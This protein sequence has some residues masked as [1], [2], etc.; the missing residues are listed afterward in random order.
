MLR[1]FAYVTWS[2]V[3][4]FVALHRPF[5]IPP[6]EI[7]VY[8]AHYKPLESR[9][10]FLSKQLKDFHSV[11]W[12]EDIDKNNITATG[13]RSPAEIANALNHYEIYKN[14]IHLNH[15]LA[16]VLEDDAVPPPHFKAKLSRTVYWA[17]FDFCFLS[18]KR[19]QLQN[20][21]HESHT[22][23]AYLINQR[24]AMAKWKHRRHV[25]LVQETAMNPMQ[26][27]ARIAAKPQ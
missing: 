6:V 23:T 15:S 21:K 10:V 11:T 19:P 12:F 26:P 2:L 8:V 4:L 27:A 1:I 17:E 25:M 16:L 18:A 3:C 14:I 7:P 9:K 20:N 5:P 13:R 22:A 24:A